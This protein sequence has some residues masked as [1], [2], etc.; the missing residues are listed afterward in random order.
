MS[1]PTGQSWKS[2]ASNKSYIPFTLPLKLE[3][4]FLGFQLF[5]DE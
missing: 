4:E 2:R 1:F 5:D 3:A